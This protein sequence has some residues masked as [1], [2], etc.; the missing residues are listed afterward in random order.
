MKWFLCM[1]IP[2]VFTSYVCA[3]ELLPFPEQKR[4]VQKNTEQRTLLKFKGKINRLDC[5]TLKE[6]KDGLIKRLNNSK[7]SSDRKYYK[8]RVHVVVDTRINK[9]CK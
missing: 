7:T 8:K 2:L 5:K 1:I 4:A 3:A 6:V 9:N